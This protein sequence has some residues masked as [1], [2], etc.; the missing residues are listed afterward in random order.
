MHSPF[1]NTDKSVERASRI[2]TGLFVAL[3]VSIDSAVAVG[4]HTGE[5]RERIFVPGQVLAEYGVEKL[6]RW[7][8]AQVAEDDE[9]PDFNVIVTG[10]GT[11]SV[12]TSTNDGTTSK[13]TTTTKTYTNPAPTEQT[14]QPYTYTYTTPSAPKL[15]EVDYN[16]PAWF[17]ERSAQSKAEFEAYSAQ[18]KANFEASKAESQAKMDAWKAANGF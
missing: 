5:L 12:T 16:P 11:T 8:E 3:F 7:A 4:W 1:N 9:D 10:S 2:I 6:E 17:T 18:S 13:T 15:E 14:V